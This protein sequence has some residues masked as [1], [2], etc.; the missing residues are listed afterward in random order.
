MQHGTIGQLTVHARVIFRRALELNAAG[1][2]LVHNHPSGDPTPSR[3]DIDVTERLVSIGY[4]LDVALLEPIVV[5]STKH[6]LILHRPAR[7]KRRQA[8]RLSASAAAPH[9]ATTEVPNTRRHAT[10]TLPRPPLVV[11][12][13]NFGKP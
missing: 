9:D 13:E 7:A 6:S 5:T 1:V 10:R 3:G 11:A 4:A 8:E 12:S 2:I